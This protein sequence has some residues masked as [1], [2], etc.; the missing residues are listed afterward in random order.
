M[1]LPLELRV[2]N[3]L[4]DIKLQHMCL[5]IVEEKS[6][7]ELTGD[8]LSSAAKDDGVEL[9]DNSDNLRTVIAHVQGF[10]DEF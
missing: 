1:T 9:I 7:E 3:T 8:G 2:P 6:D 4:N 5:I 10:E